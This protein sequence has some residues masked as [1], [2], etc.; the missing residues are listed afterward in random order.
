[1]TVEGLRSMSRLA[2]IVSFL[3][4]YSSSIGYSSSLHL[5]LTSCV[6]SWLF[7]RPIVKAELDP[8]Q[9]SRRQFRTHGHYHHPRQLHLQYN[10]LSVKIMWQ[11]LFQLPAST[12][13]TDVNK[14]ASV[15]AP[16]LAPFPLGSS[17]FFFSGSFV[18]AITRL[19]LTGAFEVVNV[20]ALIL[21]SV[22]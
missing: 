12:P 21:L 10:K 18:P 7:G 4:S 15:A 22:I 9:S 11:T 20:A 16:P 1:M 14:S 8:H 5:F 17:S 19:P 2:L 3:K 13:T 6:L